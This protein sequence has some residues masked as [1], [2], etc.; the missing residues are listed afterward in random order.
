[1]WSTSIHFHCYRKNKCDHR[2]GNQ[3][4]KIKKKKEA[5]QAQAGR[6]NLSS[7][8]AGQAEGG[9][10]AALLSHKGALH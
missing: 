6:V 1:M 2:T 8:R 3:H 5:L 9:S 10:P 7:Q 4:H